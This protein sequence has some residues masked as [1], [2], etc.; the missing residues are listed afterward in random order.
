VGVA[1]T[2]L[3]VRPDDWRLAHKSGDRAFYDAARRATGAF[4]CLF[5][6]PDGLLTEGSFTSLFVERG[7]RLLTP[8]LA[9]GLLPGVLRA[10]LIENGL[11]EEAD[12]SI[13][14]LG[15]GFLVGNSLRGLLPAVL[16]GARSG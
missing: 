2:P 3:P 13:G 14:D 15:Q 9:R 8:P 16:A 5:V 4:E 12:L 11:A 1:V 10:E 6:R 7:G